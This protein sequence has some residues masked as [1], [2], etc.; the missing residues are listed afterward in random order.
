MAGL[1]WAAK[2]SFLAGK[3]S[4]CVKLPEL[5]LHDTCLDNG[6]GVILV[7]DHSGA[8]SPRGRPQIP[9]LGFI[10][11]AGGGVADVLVYAFFLR[12]HAIPLAEHGQ[13]LG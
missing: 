8:R 13:S 6:L 9:S 1:G 5:D 12:G 7:P 2:L 11:E 10:A 4:N 3:R